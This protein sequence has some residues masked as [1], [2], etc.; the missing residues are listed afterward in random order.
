M[1]YLRMTIACF[2]I[3]AFS[4]IVYF[5]NRILPL[6]S[7]KIFIA[8]FTTTL[9]YLIFD[10]ITIYTVNH[11]PYENGIL[12]DNL[13]NYIAHI[14]FLILI[15]A[16]VYLYFI[17][18]FYHTNVQKKLSI[19]KSILYIAPFTISSICIIFLPIEYIKADINYSRGLKA[20]A[21][22]ASVACYIILTIYHL[23]HHWKNI[24]PNKS[25]SILLSTLTFVVIA[26]VQIFIP[27][28]LIS[29]LGSTLL[30]E[31]IVLSSENAEKY[32][33]DNTSFFGPS[34][35][36]LVLGDWLKYRTC[37][38]VLTIS[39]DSFIYFNRMKK[40]ET[41]VFKRISDTIHKKFKK[42][43]YFLDGDSFSLLLDNDS[44]C[45]KIIVE[46]KQS[47][48]DYVGVQEVAI[49]TNILNIVDSSQ[50][51]LDDVDDKITKFLSEIDDQ[52]LSIDILTGARNRNAFEREFIKYKED[53]TGKWIII[54]DLNDF[55][56][57]NDTYGHANGDTALKCF[58][59]ALK[60]SFSDGQV[61]RIGGDEFVILIQSSLEQLEEL[62]K[63]T[64]EACLQIQSL[65]FKL[66]FSYGFASL[67]NENAYNDA[68]Q[69]MYHNKLKYKRNS[70]AN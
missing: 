8:L 58:S 43:C 13:W 57:I 46:I 55:K 68:D 61:Y 45:D 49:D 22:Y 4:G 37:F 69:E 33:D 25:F 56:K 12:I 51:T 52:N 63:E 66:T 40:Q 60:N 38:T 54:C 3:V 50:W 20:Y 41:A 36:H 6:K 11:L 5:K 59:E 65:S 31:S 26:I 47:I 30:I 44:L 21:L 1:I 18:V 14:I 15:D 19:A 23:L 10:G 35:F 29:A 70:S 53:P 2:I 28:L 64:I 9:L 16:S 34:I 32:I 67:E 39:L 42:Y 24:N 27:T 17:Y 48:S 62:M 7:T